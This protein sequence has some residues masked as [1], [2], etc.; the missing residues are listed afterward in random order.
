MRA[1]RFSASHF[2]AVAVVALVLGCG[3]KPVQKTDSTPVAPPVVEAATEEPATAPGTPPSATE[4]LAVAAEP[5]ATA[6]ECTAV[7]AVLSA[8]GQTMIAYDDSSILVGLHA[9]VKARVDARTEAGV[10]A[11]AGR[12]SRAV[13]TWHRSRGLRLLLP[14]SSL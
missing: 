13:P 8:G 6:E 7:A 4:K 3:P 14:S 11:P 1:L 9:P 5:E 10:L 2:V 12:A